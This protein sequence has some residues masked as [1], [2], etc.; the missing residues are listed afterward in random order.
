MDDKTLHIQTDFIQQDG[1][2]TFYNHRYEPTPYDVLDNLFSV[3]APE[4]DSCLVDYGCGPGRL[5][6]Y[7]EKRFG[8]SSIG[9]EYAREFYEKALDNLASYK[10]RKERITF[11]HCKAQDYI[12]PSCAGYFYF[13][14]PFSLELLKKVIARILNSY[15]ENRRTVKLFFYYPSDEYIAYLM[16]VEELL[17]SDEIDCR[18]LF[19]GNN[20]REKIVIFEIAV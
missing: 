12:V 17:F 5:N 2:D 3:F 18:D 13:F 9:V 14:N 19:D 15:Y 20:V 10:G 7:V 1:K 6:F 16:T 8:L 11:C 4:P